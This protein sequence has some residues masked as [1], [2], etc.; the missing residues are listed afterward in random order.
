MLAWVIT[1][2]Y[3]FHELCFNLQ[4]HIILLNLLYNLSRIIVSK[5]YKNHH[6]MHYIISR[7][8]TD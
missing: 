3:V 7:S 5:N 6:N 4:Q 2:I 1:I 8:V